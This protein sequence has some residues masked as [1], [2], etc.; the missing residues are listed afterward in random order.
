[1]I[2]SLYERHNYLNK[3]IEYMVSQE[4]IE[5]DMKSAG[6]NLI[7]KFKLLEPE[8]IEYLETLTKKEQTIRIGL[9]QREDRTLVKRMN[10]KFVEARKWFFENN[11]ITDDDV[12]SI[13]KDAILTT[14]RCFNTEFDNVT[15]VEKNEYT[16]YYYLN[17]YEFYY[18]KDGLDVKGIGEEQLELHREYMLD[19]L[20]N[21]FKMNEI[22]KKKQVIQLIKEFAYYY[23][24][25]E[26]NINYYRELNVQSLF[27]INNRLFG[28]R[29]GVMYTNRDE[30]LDITFNYMAYVVPLL[31]ILI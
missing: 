6:F 13:K 31:S 20:Y 26:L 24:N 7:K 30:D 22:S 17:K 23:K 3:D 21:F 8:K 4:I 2:S 1:M 18:N 28:D 25:R 14:K 29:V 16:S 11:G 10:E 9:Y 15:F 27:Q 5:Y 12:L 19:F